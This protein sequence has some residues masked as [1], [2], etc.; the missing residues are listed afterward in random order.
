MPRRRRPYFSPLIGTVARRLL[1]LLSIGTAL[2][3][4]L[5]AIDPN[6]MWLWMQLARRLL[7]RNG[8]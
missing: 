7:T 2:V 3:A 8:N 4:L 1:V 5:R 6:W